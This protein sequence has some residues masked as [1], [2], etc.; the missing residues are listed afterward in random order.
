MALC[1]NSATFH[2]A[3]HFWSIAGEPDKAANFHNLGVRVLPES[4]HCTRR[5][6]CRTFF[7]CV[8]AVVAAVTK[9][10]NMP[11]RGESGWIRT[12]P[13]RAT[14]GRPGRP[15][16]SCA[17][18]RMLL[19]RNPPCLVQRMRQLPILGQLRKLTPLLCKIR[20]F[21]QRRHYRPGARPFPRFARR[22]LPQGRS[23]AGAR[24]WLPC[25]IATT[26]SPSA[27]YS[28]GF[29]GVCRHGT[30]WADSSTRR[31]ELKCTRQG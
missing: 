26:D 24:M 15:P 8:L 6:T 31:L 14:S 9:V 11:E 20:A 21:L 10:W 1:K 30:I 25:W 29:A 17:R 19:D 28:T 3:K 7:T 4:A 22:Q 2:R 5:R 18:G 13:A 16:A 23:N 27:A 12:I